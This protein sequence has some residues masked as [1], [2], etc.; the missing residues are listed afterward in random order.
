[1][2]LKLGTKN[3]SVRSVQEML[4]FLGTHVAAGPPEEDFVPLKVDGDFG[5][6]TEAAVLEFQRDHGVLAD[7]IVGPITLELIEAEYRAARLALDS[8]GADSVEETPNRLIFESSPADPYNGQGYSKV[9]LRSDTALRYR[10]V[11]EAVHSAGALLTSAG[12]RRD[13]NAP[14]SA[15]RSA[16]SFHYSGR[17]LDLALHSGMVNPKN[18]PYVVVRDGEPR[19]H[20]VY[21]R[22]NAGS[23]IQL[24]LSNVITYNNRSGNLT[25]DGNFLDLTALFAEQGFARIRARPDFP[26]GGS[27]IGA[28][29]WHFQ[30]E[31][32]LIKGESTFGA[33]LLKVYSEATV[34]PTPPW[35][36]RDRVF[37]VNWG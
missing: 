36:F 9:W 28:E 17:A 5:K 13:L 35:K 4:N 24:T 26:S 1:M 21:A 2:A 23:G 15:G 37:G 6:R 22:C 12:G 10:K 19:L 11:Y 3:E 7:G 33:E 8:P 30:D 34:A 25:A 20:R 27:T 32:G 16:T 29:W 14:V 18:D 31:T